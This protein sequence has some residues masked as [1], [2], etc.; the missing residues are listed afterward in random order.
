MAST[1]ALPSRLGNLPI[2]FF[3]MVM[4]LSGLTIAW[5]KA[6]SLGNLGLPALPRGLLL[7]TA[8]VFTVLAVLYTAKLIRYTGS[9]VSEFHHPVKLNFFP[10]ISISLLLLAIAML[11]VDRSTSMALWMMGT[12]WHLVLT[13]YVVNAWMHHEHF[14]VE[15]INPAWFIPAVG[16]VVVP[17]AG[18]PLGYPDVSWFFFS[19]GLLFWGVLLTIVFYRLMFHA[20]MDSK[21]LPT[22]FILIA[23]PAVGFISYMKLNGEVDAFARVLYYAGLF[24]TLVMFTQVPRFIRLRFSLAWWAYSFPLAAISIASMLMFEHTGNQAFGLIAAGL[25]VAVTVMVLFLVVRTL[26]A[27]LAHGICIPEH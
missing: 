7:L 14:K 26:K 24:M 12:L 10:A 16:N 4:G 8:A 19:V 21:L 1:Q 13:L 9:V 27:V 17:V 6:V 23:P 18:V 2:S 5:E 15:H 20:P 11:P 22:L 25:L 3:A